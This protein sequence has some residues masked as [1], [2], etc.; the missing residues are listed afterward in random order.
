MS[1]EFWMSLTAILLAL[2][3]LGLQALST[4]RER[5]SLKVEQDKVHEAYSFPLMYYDRYDCLFFRLSISNKAKSDVSIAKIVL[6]GKDG[7]SYLPEEYTIPDLHNENGLSFVNRNDTMH[8]DFFNLRSENI[9]DQLRIPAYGHVSGFVVFLDGPVI[10]SGSESFKVEV[11]TPT[12]VYTT[13][14]TVEKLPENLT[15]SNAVKSK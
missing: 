10:A 3:S 1:L 2:L 9:L 6:R 15:P 4:W 5:V 7:K 13:M 14:V 11:Q 8:Y 12:K